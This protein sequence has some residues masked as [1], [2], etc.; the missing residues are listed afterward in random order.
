MKLFKYEM[1]K[2]LFNKMRLILLV[3]LF[4]MYGFLGFILSADVEMESTPGEPKAAATYAEMIEKSR[5]T[6]NEETLRKSQ[7]TVKAA[8]AEYGKGEE[9]YRQQR[10]NPTLKFS[11]KYVDF[12]NQV[13]MYWY[14][15]TEQNPDNIL[16][17]YPIQE[18]L[19]E[20]ETENR[21]DSYEYRYYQERLDLEKQIGEPVFENTGMWSSFFIMYDWMFVVILLLMAL[22]YFISQL[23][24]QEVRTEMDSIVLCSLK[25]RSEIVTAKLLAATLTSVILAAGYLGASFVGMMIGSGNFSG[26][27]APARCLEIYAQVPLNLTVGALVAF[28]VVWLILVTVVF[29]LALALISSK[30]KNQ[31]SAFGI[32]IAV[33]LAG[34]MSG[35]IPKSLY[36]ILWPV[37]DFHFGALAMFNSIFGGFKTYNI[38]G[39][40][41]SY[42]MMA[43]VVC[44]VLGTLACLLTYIAQ[45]KRSVI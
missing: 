4:G 35:S 5:G 6:L 16:G 22:T 1:K 7:D 31:S 39:T 29:G 25:G 37:I 28:S 8:I 11:S 13:N 44:L 19:K 30:M 43:F 10:T 2:L 15:P 41:V 23:F 14:G 40:P 38:L 36:S 27:G 3:L 26:L 12:G 21:T 17:V 33:L 18:K 24:T 9:M 20:L 42:G 32:G 34:M 45:K